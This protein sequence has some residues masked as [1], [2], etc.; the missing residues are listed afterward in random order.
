M[1]GKVGRWEGGVVSPLTAVHITLVHGEEKVKRRKKE[2]KN[3]NRMSNRENAMA[4]I[5]FKVLLAVIFL[6]AFNDLKQ[7]NSYNLAHT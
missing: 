3:E 6:P 5:C 1:L 7:I 2:R 4:Q